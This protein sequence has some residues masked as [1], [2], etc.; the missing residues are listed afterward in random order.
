MANLQ[1]LESGD[2]YTMGWISALPLE[3]AAATAM[4]DE[5]HATPNDFNRSP[6]D[7][8]NYT[9]GRMGE[10]N[11]V[12]A[13]LPAG[14]YGT[15]SAATTASQ[16]LSSFPN[17]R[18]GLMVG[19]G[20][21]IPRLEEYDI[22]LGDVVV[23]QPDGLC[24]GV[25]QYDLGKAGADGSFQRRGMLNRP[26]LV[27]LNALSSLQARHIKSASKISLYVNKVLE[28][29]P[30]MKKPRPK[31][32]G[33]MYPG[34]DNDKLFEPT[35]LHM[36]GPKC[37]ACEPTR[38]IPRDAR[39]S[40]DP[41]IHYGVIASGNTLV[42][43]AIHRDK[44]A[45]GTGEECICF[46]MEAAGIMN[47]FPCVVIRGICD[48]ADSHKNDRWQGYAAA[49]AAAYAKELLEVIP[50]GDLQRTEKAIKVLNE[51]CGKTVLS[52]IIVEHLQKEP[53]SSHINLLYFF[54]DFVDK[55]KQ[56]H[57]NMIRTFIQQLYIQEEVS[58]HI[59]EEL[60]ERY[61]GRNEQPDLTSLEH[62]FTSMLIQASHTRVVIDA[63]DESCQQRNT[64]EWLRRI[65]TNQSVA[66]NK[67][68]VI[69]IS[70]KEYGIESA[71]LKWVPERYTLPIKA[72]DVNKDISSFVHSQ[73]R[74]DPGLE[75]WRERPDVQIEIESKLTERANGMFRW[76]TCQLDTLEN[77]LDLTDLRKALDDLPDGLNETYSRILARVD[78]RNQEKATAMLQLLV[79]AKEEL[80]LNALVDALA[81]R[82]GE[83]GLHYDPRNKMPF[84]GEIVKY[85]RS[86]ARRSNNITALY[87]ASMHG[88]D[89]VVSWMLKHDAQ[90]ID[91][92]CIGDINHDVGSTALEVATQNYHE[93]TVRVLLANGATP[94]MK[95][96]PDVRG[97]F[98]N[99]TVIAVRILRMLLDHDAKPTYNALML[100]VLKQ[101]IQLVQFLLDNGA[102]MTDKN[103]SDTFKELH[104]TTLLHAACWNTCPDVE[105]I[106]M[107]LDHGADINALDEWHRTALD[108]A[109]SEEVVKF[110]LDCGAD[111]TPSRPEDCNPLHRTVRYERKE[112]M[113][114]FSDM[115]QT[116]LL[117][118][119]GA[120]Q[121]ST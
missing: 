110:L 59:L 51:G 36:G 45:E 78:A 28:Q 60:S 14:V 52:S 20:A 6:L 27:L 115:V 119:N 84:P 41:E 82:Q 18:I 118:M 106:K 11:L 81:I 1:A 114:S 75:R 21:G 109:G 50:C 79:W 108:V 72:D 19:I 116:S 104:G 2:M 58:R 32:P 4:L 89:R 43:D 62:T 83:E 39:D 74:L 97:S 35:Y 15:T 99:K 3:L 77:C 95:V 55:E 57:E 25:V 44:L 101:N 107:I 103:E 120:K 63:L 70:R 38:E 68:N 67:L 48:Y 85:R 105:I 65:F 49:T 10:H 111:I 80:T 121:R 71:F 8:N 9:F 117:R 91:N 33:Y 37:T 56:S 54:F 113:P 22:R 40:T 90:T 23:S 64:L 69:I 12:I 47:T 29:Y 34:V 7:Q 96:V 13:S 98:S 31:M 61:A 73:I 46:E 17:I 92:L 102:P 24:G 53:P 30:R 94:V 87:F 16:M 86:P 42:K 26:P 76:V 93:E 100:A 88:M 66:P 5:E 112:E